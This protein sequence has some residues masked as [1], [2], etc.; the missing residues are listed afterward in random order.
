[1]QTALSLLFQRPT[2]FHRFRL[3]EILGPLKFGYSVSGLGLIEFLDTQLPIIFIGR[4]LGISD[5]GIYNRTYALIQLPL[6]QLGVSLSRVMYSTFNETKHDLQIVARIAIPSMK[7][8][9]V[10]IF[11]LA[12]GGAAASTT[13]VTLI[14]G[15][16][17]ANAAPVFSI[18]AISTAAAVSANLL[19]TLNEALSLT[20]NKA[21]LQVI[22][23]VTM[24]TLIF[25][26]G[27]SGVMEVSICLL[28]SRLMFFFGQFIISFTHIGIPSKRFIGIVGP[29]L[30][31]AASVVLGV[32]GAECAG[33]YFELGV[34]CQMFADLV[35]S[36]VIYVICLRFL[37]PEL[38]QRVRTWLGRKIAI[39]TSK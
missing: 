5:L 27:S 30:V 13:V 18:L 32:C 7:Y 17:W 2:I 6:E 15:E 19:A 1:L 9:C 8:L 38:W 11:P 22:C 14:L 4:F 35:F 23:T 26:F 3:A 29:G 34:S 21:I 28:A 12:F 24:A 10:L 36:A 39:Q 25:I 20:R 16:R 31:T 37:V 33:V